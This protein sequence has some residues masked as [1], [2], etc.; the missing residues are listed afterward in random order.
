MASKKA[1]KKTRPKKVAAALRQSGKATKKPASKVGLA[2]APA[3]AGLLARKIADMIDE[4]RHRVAQSTNAAL[5][6]LYWRIAARIQEDILKERRADYGARVV[7][8]LGRQLESKFGR[9][10][11]EKN[12]RRMVQFAEAFPNPEIVADHVRA[13]SA[14]SAG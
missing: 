14:A 8:E 12:L 1:G 11:G 6:P 7:V 5:T 4:A 10:F 13:E 2:R 9:G 3:R